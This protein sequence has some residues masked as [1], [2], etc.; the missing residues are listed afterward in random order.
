LE[1]PLR[2]IRQSP[3]HVFPNLFKYKSN[4]EQLVLE[5]CPIQSKV[6]SIKNS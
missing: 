3:A 6:L 2:D 5:Q 1:F 4:N